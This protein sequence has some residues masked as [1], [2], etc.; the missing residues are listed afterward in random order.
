MTAFEI[1]GLP[2]AGKTTLLGELRGLDFLLP[3][4]IHDNRSAPAGARAPLFSR[5]SWKIRATLSLCRGCLAAETAGFSSLWKWRREILCLVNK[6]SYRV[7]K[8]R[9]AALSGQALVMADSGIVQPLLEACCRVG[10][11]EFAGV[12]VA[13]LESLP[14]PCGLFLVTVDG[15]TAMERYQR[16]EGRF[17]EGMNDKEG[18]AAYLRGEFFLQSVRDHLKKHGCVLRELDGRW[19]AGV[20]AETVGREIGAILRCRGENGGHLKTAD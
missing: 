14:V 17:F 7:T 15:K 12:A 6:L 20:L 19:E 9:E 16:R 3:L 1:A 10:D 8:M 5:A 11:A 4:I 18:E 2:G 13:M